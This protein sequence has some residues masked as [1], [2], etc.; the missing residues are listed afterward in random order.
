MIS[1]TSLSAIF[2]VANL[3]LTPVV[4]DNSNL[5]PPDRGCD[6]RALIGYG[7]S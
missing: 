2:F 5:A 3:T 7:G 4:C 6:R 1:L